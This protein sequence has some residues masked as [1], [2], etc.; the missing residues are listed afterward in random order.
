LQ[1]RYARCSVCI[2]ESFY[3]HCLFCFADSTSEAVFCPAVEACSCPWKAG[4]G[5]WESCRNKIS[6]LCNGEWIHLN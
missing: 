2:A 1:C 5:I 3:P 6:K 4:F